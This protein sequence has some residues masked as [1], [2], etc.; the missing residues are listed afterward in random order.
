[1]SRRDVSLFDVANAG[2]NAYN[3]HQTSKLRSEMAEQNAMMQF[4]LEQMRMAQEL[5]AMKKQ[6]IIQA[7]NLILEVE[8]EIDRIDVASSHYP[9]HSSLSMDILENMLQEAGI[10]SNMFEEIHD[11]ERF[12]NMQKHMMEVSSKVS[13]L[14]AN[15]LEIKA[16]LFRYSTED[17]ELSEAIELT[18]VRET[19][20]VDYD[21]KSARW[22]NS[23]HDW[24]SLEKQEKE[25]NTKYNNMLVITTI[26]GIIVTGAIFF[27]LSELSSMEKEEIEGAAGISG[28]IFGF[29]LLTTFW[30]KD[31]YPVIKADNPLK[32]L[33]ENVSEL[34]EK[35]GYLNS[36]YESIPNL[37]GG[38]TTSGELRGLYANWMAYVDQHSPTAGEQYISPPVGET[39]QTPTGDIDSLLDGVI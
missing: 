18:E 33:K 5:E 2:M 13:R 10:E 7:R 37:Y 28:C 23:Q 8:E 3:M 32:L 39:S 20:M 14:D 35:L 16:N 38:L 21:E 11:I 31:A 19:T 29:A 9:A 15:N 6:M 17:D 26:L 30:I 4:E 36:K 27:G 1:M 34:E 22:Q 24:A 12:R 25:R